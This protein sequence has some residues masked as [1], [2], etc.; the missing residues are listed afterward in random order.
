LCLENDVL[1]G[2]RRHHRCFTGRIYRIFVVR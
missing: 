1:A 2:A